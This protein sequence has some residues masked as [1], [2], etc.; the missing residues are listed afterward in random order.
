MRKSHV[1]EMDALSFH[2]PFWLHGFRRTS[3]LFRWLGMLKPV[4]KLPQEIFSEHLEGPVEITRDDVGVPHVQAGSMKDALFVQGF[5]HGRERAFQM[6]LSRRLPLGQLAELLGPK[7]LVF[8]RFMRKLHIAH[9]A[10]EAVGTWSDN[11]KEYVQSYVEGINY[12]FSTQPLP[13]EYRFLKGHL[14]PWTVE[15]TN[16]VAYQLAW[17]LNSI[18]H[19]KWISDQLGSDTDEVVR[20]WL[21]GAINM[22]APTI[23][24]DTGRYEAWGSIGVGSNNW[25]VDGNHSETGGPLLANDPHLMPQLPSIWYEM[26]LEGGA[27]H[28]FGAS[29][30]G[31][32]GI[33]IG[34]NQYIAWGVTNIDP[35]VQD[36][37]RI[38]MESDQVHYRV[39]D[40]M[41]TIVQREE[42]IH[43]RGQEDEKLSCYD[44]K[45]G[46]V[47]YSEDQN[48]HIAMAWAGFQPL[49]LAQAV[50]RLDRAH[51]WETF[52]TALAEWWVPAQNFVY[53]DSAGH[54][55]YIAAGR[56]PMRENGPWRGVV[57]GNTEKY[58]WSGWV[59]WTQMPRIF[60]PD[61]GYIV[62]ANNPVV[63]DEAEVPLFGRYALG[64][65]AR[66]IQELIERVPRHSK[67][68][69]RTIQLDV[70]S[71]P[72]DQLAKKLRETKIPSEWRET[73]QDFHGQVTIDSAA[74]TILYLFALA[75]VP[76]PIRRRLDTPFFRDIR[77]GLPGTHPY[78]ETWWSLLGERLIPAVLT[79]WHELD[80]TQAI[81][82][83]Q[84]WLHKHFGSTSGHWAWGRAHKV[85]L[86]HP[87]GDVKILAPLFARR[88]LPMPGDL[89][90]PLQTAFALE[91]NLP[92]PRPVAFMPSYRQ[93]MDLS[94]PVESVG[95][96]LTGQSGHPL[97]SHYDNLVLP[98]LRGEYFPLGPGM[99]THLWFMMSPVPGERGDE[100]RNT[101]ER[102]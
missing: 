68:T 78:P 8:D 81:T 47:I 44:T 38:R 55:G 83:A 1:N 52:N 65:R 86:F 49:P 11:T 73:L 100:V 34:Q 72:L 24:P 98:Y 75:S 39:D 84:E 3:H 63:G 56:V 77:P 30:P 20:E 92:W 22:T 27:L 96:H 71:E 95:I 26:F 19:A 66:R 18:W 23:V 102:G 28:V 82:K 76:E 5:I 15:D 94:T 6:D 79:H 21:F 70:Y 74:P 32:P 80:I 93:I 12:A 99:P 46:P 13:P 54:I 101:T 51:D 43:V 29:L 91:P 59:E 69:F 88:M 50:L 90:T 48:H 61:R 16:A 57:D 41:E 53:G 40:K 7:T 89:Y 85:R 36:L 4:Q 14:R 35:D 87:F 9:W 25:V 17:S 37:Y 60:D 42:I 58:R 97:S 67:D 62:S 31:A 64:T 45:W 33:V 10:K 2:Y